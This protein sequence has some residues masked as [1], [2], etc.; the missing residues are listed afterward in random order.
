VTVR[1]KSDEELPLAD[2]NRHWML[3]TR[4]EQTA[5]LVVDSE[6]YDMTFESKLFQNEN[7]SEES[8]VLVG[9][10]HPKDSR[11]ENYTNFV[12]CVSSQLYIFFIY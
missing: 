3:Y 8:L 5:Q 10:T 2:G 11:L 12:G 7:H 4:K 1:V 9:A 6:I